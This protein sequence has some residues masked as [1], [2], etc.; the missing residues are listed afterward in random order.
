MAR[1]PLLQLSDISLTFGGNPVF[2]GLSLNIQQGDRVALVGRNGSGKSTLMKVMAGLI[3]PDHGSRVV[4]PGVSVGYME[5]EPDLSGF[6]TLGDFAASELDPAEAYRI[7]M[8]AE[9]LKFR[10]ETPVETASG[11]E[12]RRAA[13]AKL[14]AEGPELMLLDEPTNHLDIEAIGWLENQ[15]RETRRAFVLIS[16]DRAFL[17]ALTRATLWIDRGQ[18]RRNEQGFESFEEWREKLWIGEDEARH[19]LDRKIKAEARWAVEGISA[20]RKRNQGRVRAL[21]ALRA[22]RASQIKR[23]GVAAMEL[24][25]GPQ[26]GKR[27]IEASGLSKRFGDKQIVCDF[28]L[29]VLRGDRV[30]FVGPNGVGKT[31]LLKMLTGETAPDAGTV[32]L[33]T[34]LEIAVF[35]QAR[36]TLDPEQTLWDGLVNDPDMSVKGRSDQVMVR[37]VAKHV[38]GYLKDFLFDEQ[39]ARGPIRALSGGE[40]ARLLLAKL[41]AKP[42]NLLILDEPTNDLDVETLD[43]LQ[44]LLGDYDGTVLLVSHDR[45]FIDRVATTTIAMEGDGRATVYAGGWSDYQAQKALAEPEAKSAPRKET[46][47]KPVETAAAPTPA[48]RK[49]GLSFTEK[50]RLEALPGIIEKLEHEIGKINELLSDPDLF[51]REPVKFAKA[52]EMLTERQGALEAAETEW[53]ELEEKAQNG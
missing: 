29:R 9:G 10:P 38:V 50:H 37:G 42:S 28:D 35:D 21:Q 26:S 2:E 15:L 27:V 53:L 5:Q 18:V 44:D 13:L 8:V 19:K 31:T 39:Q 49:P 33:G 1:A 11:G 48:P 47:S 51:T 23:Q 32:K 45:D 12:R 43:L 40:R 22:E 24:E 34:N 30:A 20:R 17:R 41:M 4:P 16:H 36:A 3:E 14:L 46:A 25:T 7:E 6:A 52:T